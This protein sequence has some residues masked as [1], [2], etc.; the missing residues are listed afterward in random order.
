MFIE[1]SDGTPVNLDHISFVEKINHEFKHLD[2]PQ[3]M[4]GILGIRSLQC[5]EEDANKI[6][7]ILLGCHRGE[8]QDC[9]VDVGELILRKVLSMSEE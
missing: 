7:A 6:K 4:I 8:C 5:N 2:N 1:L 3:Y 9:D